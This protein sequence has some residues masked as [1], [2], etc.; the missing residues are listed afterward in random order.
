MFGP[1]ESLNGEIFSLDLDPVRTMRSSCSFLSGQ[2]EAVLY[3]R[4]LPGSFFILTQ[5]KAFFFYSRM[6]VNS[7][8]LRQG[9]IGEGIPE[10][11]GDGSMT[12]LTP[13]G[14]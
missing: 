4:K 2:L 8:R 12:T 1:L 7:A 11:R 14:R 9:E 6:W 10:I 13:G 5:C 3:S